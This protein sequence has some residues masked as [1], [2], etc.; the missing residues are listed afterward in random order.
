MK[1]KNIKKKFLILFII[2]VILFIV[3][4]SIILKDRKDLKSVKICSDEE[5]QGSP[6][7]VFI[8]LNNREKYKKIRAYFRSTDGSSYV[9]TDVDVDINK[10]STVSESFSSENLVVG[11]EYMISAIE[12][13]DNKG[14]N[15]LYFVNNTG[16]KNGIISEGTVKILEKPTLTNLQL[17]GSKNIKFGDSLIFKIDYTGKLD[18]A[19]ILIKNKETEQYYYMSITP[20]DTTIVIEKN[21]LYENMQPGNYYISDIYLNS[22]EGNVHYSKVQ[23]DENTYKLNF[24]IE[25]TITD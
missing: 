13:I 2:L 17:T 11:K 20:E 23:E 14:K 25:F 21:G 7:G 16:E 18:V 15:T 4:I 24:D 19:S 8:D 1:E 12:L 5:T 22:G 10:S 9:S 6:I 3:V